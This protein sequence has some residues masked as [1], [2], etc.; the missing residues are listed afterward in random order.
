MYVIRVLAILGVAACGAKTTPA[1]TPAPVA[2][3]AP[4]H[5][6]G[7]ILGRWRVV[8]CV[9]SPGDPA[10]CARGEIVFEANTWSVKLPCCER[11]GTYSIRSSTPDRVTITSE[12]ETSEIRFD[13]DGT[14]HW[15]P[16]VDDGR[17]GAL[18]FVR[19]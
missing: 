10:D 17:V 1:P 7:A 13:P 9:T 14:A 16:G 6:P 4:S 18:S 5:P 8:G 2:T 3:P 15:D 12:G 11:N 19:D